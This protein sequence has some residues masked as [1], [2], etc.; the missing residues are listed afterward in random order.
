[1]KFM[2]TWQL[3]PEYR[4]DVLSVW[5]AIPNAKRSDLGKGVKFIGRWHD[6]AAG[7]GVLIAETKDLGALNRY[8]G[9]WAPYMDINVVPVMDDRE[10][11]A[12]AKKIVADAKG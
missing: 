10:S 6:M 3:Y 11:G 2:V 8:I 4:L 5:G 12:L 9:Q 1:M 7:N